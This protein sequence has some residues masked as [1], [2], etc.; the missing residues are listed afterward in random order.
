[1]SS[2]FDRLPSELALAIFTRLSYRQL[3]K[4][5]RVCKKW[6]EWF[7]DDSLDRILFRKG[8][9][10][11]MYK[12][13]KYKIHPALGM[14]DWL[15]VSGDS[16]Q[17]EFSRGETDYWDR[18][19]LDNLKHR[20][21]LKHFITRPA[22]SHLVV[23]MEPGARYTKHSLHFPIDCTRGITVLDLLQEIAEFW[24]YGRIDTSEWGWVGWKPLSQ[25]D[26]GALLLEAR[27]YDH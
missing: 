21:L 23:N 16:A 22:I 26:N 12:P 19:Q 7:Y 24:G 10:H 15:H 1:M 3:L 6:R 9:A 18:E 17:L 20:K 2:P 13:H 14:F 8:L 25:L 11:K 5:E 4:V 27:S